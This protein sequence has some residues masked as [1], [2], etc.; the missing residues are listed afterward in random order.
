MGL[1]L[2]LH[3]V[4]IPSNIFYWFSFP[5]CIFL[6]KVVTSHDLTWIELKCTKVLS[7]NNCLIHNMKFKWKVFTQRD[8]ICVKL[9]SME[10]WIFVWLNPNKI[11]KGKWIFIY[12]TPTVEVIYN[13]YQ[14]IINVKKEQQSRPSVDVIV[15]LRSRLKSKW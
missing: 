8:N 3:A 13:L 1:R 2:S 15:G 6:A 12:A 5:W 10:L 14:K 7:L 4:V 9:F 11:N